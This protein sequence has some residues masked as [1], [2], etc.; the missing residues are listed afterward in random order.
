MT[1]LA[2]DA[3]TVA[4]AG[5]PEEQRKLFIYRTVSKFTT[6]YLIEFHFDAAGRAHAAWASE[7]LEQIYGCSLEEYKR[8]RPGWCHPPESAAESARRR[9][10]VERGERVEDVKHVL[11]DDGTSRWLYIVIQ[12][13][14]ESQSTLESIA[15]NSPEWLVLLDPQRRIGFINR[16]IFGVPPPQL[17]GKRI[18]DT[19]LPRHRRRVRDF[20][21]G[22]LDGRG[23]GEYLQTMQDPALGTRK[24]FMRAA[25]EGRRR[26]DGRGAHLHRGHRAGGPRA[27]AAPAGE[28]AC[29]D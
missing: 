4:Q 27:D 15:S 24:C 6:G 12:P 8:R 17:I 28:R 16:P 21:S 9:A 22:V 5:D 3:T 23:R 14:R 18:E 2:R 13:L 29:Q 20:V 11:R 19:A 7:G 1:L 26:R 10:A 25:S